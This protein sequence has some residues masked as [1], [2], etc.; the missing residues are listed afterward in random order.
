MYPMQWFWAPQVHL[1]WSGSVAQKI[2]LKPWF[3]AIPTK[4]GDGELELR[5]FEH[6][7]YGRQLGWLSE[8][9]LDLARA[10]PPTTAEGAAALARLTE[11]AAEISKLKAE[12]NSAA[13]PAARTAPPSEQEVEEFLRQL[14]D[15]DSARFEQVCARLQLAPVKHALKVAP[16]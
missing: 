11:T 8:L 4:A 5:V 3:D 2:G 6:A 13:G 12:H 16:A 14:K 1:P 15:S 9:L 10:A 7:S